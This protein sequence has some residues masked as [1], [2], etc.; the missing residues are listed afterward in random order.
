MM[1]SKGSHAAS[2]PRDDESWPVYTSAE[3]A[4]MLG[5]STDT[6]SNWRSVGKGPR[7]VTEGAKVTVYLRETVHQWLRDHERQ[8][9]VTYKPKKK[10]PP[11]PKPAKKKRKDK[12]DV[13]TE[14]QSPS[15]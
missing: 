1:N 8:T 2:M 10:E 11:P 7:F 14:A 12:N 6:L 9:T 13:P 15:A 3:V 5:I 4:K